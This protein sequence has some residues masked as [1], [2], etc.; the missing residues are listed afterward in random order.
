M[1]QVPNEI[2]NEIAET[3]T[4]ATEWGRKMFP[5]PFAEMQQAVEQEEAALLEKG[6]PSKVVTAYQEVM[7]LLLEHAAISN[8]LSRPEKMD[9]RQAL[10]EVRSPAE[11]A[12]LMSMEHRMS[13]KE[14]SQLLTM[15][16]AL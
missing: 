3:Q 10:P 4:L 5:L 7:P 14:I 13:S 2:W 9:L 6:T 1:Y 16:Q 8:Y 12:L 15:L 11:A